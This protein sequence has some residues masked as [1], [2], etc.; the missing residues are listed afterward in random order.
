MNTYRLILIFRLRPKIGRLAF[1]YCKI[2]RNHLPFYQMAKRGNSM[3]KEDHL[4]N[5]ISISADLTETG[6]KASAKSRTLSAFDRLCGGVVDIANAH[7]EGFAARRRAKTEGEVILIEAAA[8]YGVHKMEKDNGFAER[9]LENQYKKTLKLQANKDAVFQGVLEDFRNS[10]VSEE[11][12]NTGPQELS[13]EFLDRFERYAEDASTEDLQRRWSKILAGEIRKPGTFNRKIM[14]SVD[15]LEGDA[16][17]LFAK[18]VP[19]E[20]D[21]VLFKPLMPT[22]NFEQLLLLTESGLVVDPGF[23]HH[24]K[25]VELAMGDGSKEWALPFGALGISVPYSFLEYSL[26]E[27]VI[28]NTGVMPGAPVLILTELGKALCS[29]IGNRNESLA[30]SYYDQLVPIFG[31]NKLHMYE[32]DVRAQQW[33]RIVVAQ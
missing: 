1:I 25:F 4:S 18:L 10:P 8:Q 27:E 13:D 33:T 6:V 23:G 29:I 26:K 21:G 7:L 11:D 3:E 9:A 22:I 20:A 12:E 30:Q 14:R 32:I 2:I 24:R 17:T 5:E 15:E 28:L 31:A 19:Y 16:A